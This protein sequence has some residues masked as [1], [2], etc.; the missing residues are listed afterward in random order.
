[1]VGEGRKIPPVSKAQGPKPKDSQKA[2]HSRPRQAQRTVSELL[3]T[4]QPLLYGFKSASQ[5]RKPRRG[6]QAAAPAAEG[7]R[8]R[9]AIRIFQRWGGAFPR[10]VLHKTL[11]QRL[12][13]RDQTVM[14][15]RKGERGKETESM[16]A[17]LAEPA[18]VLDPVVNVV[19]RLLAP[20]AM[21]DDRM[22]QTQRT[23]A[24]DRFRITRR[25]VETWL[26]IIRRKWDKDNRT[27]WEALTE[28]NLRRIV[29]RREPSSFLLN[30]SSRRILSYLCPLATEDWPVKHS[31]PLPRA[32]SDYDNRAHISA[33]RLQYA[34][35]GCT[36]WMALGT[37][38]WCKNVTKRPQKLSL[39]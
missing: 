11:S 8:V 22:A 29:P 33:S 3:P 15:I 14:G 34:R 1:M 6:I 31:K 24:R 20:P 13:T 38:I 28:Q 19:M 5:K 17:E 37:A 26:A 12:T 39:W 16:F 21:A 35:R 2:K 27:A 36:A 10:V 23:P 9:N 4:S 18:V 30:L 32:D 25:P 7:G